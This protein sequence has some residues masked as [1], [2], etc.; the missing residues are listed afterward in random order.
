MHIKS[1]ISLV[2]LM[3]FSVEAFADSRCT[4]VKKTFFRSGK[5]TCTYHSLSLPSSSITSREIKYELPLGIPPAEGWPVAIIYQGTLFP[6]EFSNKSYA[7][8]GGINETKTIKKL[9]DNGYAVLAPRAALEFAWL[10]NA[11]GVISDNLY[12]TTSDF[13]FLTNVFQGIEDGLFGPLNPN[14]KY[15]TGL[16]SGGY[17]TSRMAVSFPG[18][19]KALVIHSASYAECSGALCLV[20][21][22]LPEDHPPTF[23]IHGFYD[24][25]VPWY[26]MDS[27]YDRLLWKGISTG[28]HTNFFAG[29]KWLPESAGLVLDWFD[30][31]P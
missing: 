23:F 24:P 26:T 17:N 27:Y 10:T 18:E 8:F 25:I 16:S 4:E 15:A 30:E 9:L 21:L 29:H 20:P 14:R 31:Y 28:R 13:T 11:A 1:T 6:V 3:L 12:H 7:P 19:F 5:V 2:L 22:L